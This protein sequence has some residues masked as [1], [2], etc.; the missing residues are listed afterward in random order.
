M[1]H[2]FIR[3][4]NCKGFIT[5]YIGLTGNS[6]AFLWEPANNN[7]DSYVALLETNTPG[8]LYTF[9]NRSETSKRFIECK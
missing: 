5:I 2:N 8:S 1:L 9:R 3:N 7:A 4:F 6:V